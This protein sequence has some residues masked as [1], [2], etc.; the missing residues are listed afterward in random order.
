[1]GVGG[2]ASVRRLGTYGWSTS[3]PPRNTAC[4]CTQN[5]NSFNSFNSGTGEISPAS[6]VREDFELPPTADPYPWVMDQWN[7]EDLRLDE[8]TFLLLSERL[9]EALKSPTGRVDLIGSYS[10][11]ASFDVLRM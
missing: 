5:R 9:G 4:P 6:S 7:C 8:R 1:M 10:A 11:D 2:P 3:H